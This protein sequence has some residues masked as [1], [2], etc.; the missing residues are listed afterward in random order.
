[1]LNNWLRI[2]SLLVA[3]LVVFM[4][5]ASLI[6]GEAHSRWFSPRSSGIVRYG[7]DAFWITLGVRALSA[8]LLFYWFYREAKLDD[9]QTF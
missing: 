2:V 1:M 6:S 4:I 5:I 3:L 9:D 8:G 7:E